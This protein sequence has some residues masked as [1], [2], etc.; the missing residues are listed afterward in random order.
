VELLYTAS[1]GSVI[2]R[3]VAMQRFHRDIQGFALHALVQRDANLEVQG[4]VLL[5]MDPG[6]YF[7]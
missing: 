4:R 7:L 2:R 6:T 5:G 3:E 1:G